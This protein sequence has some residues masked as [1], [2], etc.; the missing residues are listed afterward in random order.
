MKK[1]TVILATVAS[2]LWGSAALADA[3]CRGPAKDGNTWNLICSADNSGD[4]QTEYQCDY[5]L[6]VTNADGETTQMEATGS[7]GQGLSGVVLWSNVQ[8][9][10]SDITS[11]SVVSGSCVQQ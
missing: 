10:G 4:A 2:V 3:S 8:S 1:A 11:A 7:V 9:D 6:S 5:I